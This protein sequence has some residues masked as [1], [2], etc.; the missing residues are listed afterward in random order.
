MAFYGVIILKAKFSLYLA[1]IAPELKRL[2]AILGE[3]YDYVSVLS[4][5]SKG[6]SL[7]ISQR[8]KNVT[9]QNITTERGSVVR[10]YKNG[11]YSE[12]A[13]NSFD[14]AEKLAEKAKEALDSQ[15]ALLKATGSK[16]YDTAKLDDSPAELF[17][18][19]EAEILPEE[20]DV[21]E[22]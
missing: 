10:V 14:S 13:F 1:S 21:G 18:E 2:A 7:T 16:V 11:L 22:F 20:C 6:I 17:V 4:T 12:Y 19:K 3:S 15:L 9:T 5:D 8:A